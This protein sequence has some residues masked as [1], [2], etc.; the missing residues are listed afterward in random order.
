MKNFKTVLLFISLQAIAR[1]LFS[2]KIIDS[3]IINSYPVLKGVIYEYDYSTSFQNICW[4][5][6]GVTIITL[7][8]SIFHNKKG[9]VVGLHFWGN[10]INDKVAII[11]RNEEDEFYSYSNL[12]VSNVCRGDIVQKG[13][14]LG[15]AGTSD[16]GNQKQLNFMIYKKGKGLSFKKT[17]EY[18]RSLN[19]CEQLPTEY[20]YF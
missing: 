16:V 10:D 19:S 17:V 1:E 4:R 8:D 6:S 14:F 18:L 11:I 13:T 3:I 9:K 20:N 5:D 2:Q 7:N 15:L 12:K